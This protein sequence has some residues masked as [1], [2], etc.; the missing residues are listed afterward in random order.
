MEAELGIL[1]FVVVIIL[2]VIFFKGLDIADDWYH[3]YL[4]NKK[5]EK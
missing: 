5:T 4:K 2:G 1:K 3:N